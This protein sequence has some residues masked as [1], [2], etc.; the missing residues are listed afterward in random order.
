MAATSRGGAAGGTA[1]PARS[2]P[3][4]LITSIP[5]TTSDGDDHGAVRPSRSPAIGALQRASGILACTAAARAAITDAAK[6]ATL[7]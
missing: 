7:T 2:P 5:A 6:M 4:T 1:A 3:T